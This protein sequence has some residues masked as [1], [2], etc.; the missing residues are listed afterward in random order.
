[1]D[2]GAPIAASEVRFRSLFEN[3]PEL[4][5]YQNPAGIILDANPAF[6]AVVEKSKEQVI[7][8]P[9]SD[10]LPLRAQPIFTQK[11]REA[12]AGK[13]VRFE[14]F[15]SQGQS[16]PRHWDVVK[17]P[18]RQEGEVVGVHMVARDIT[19][20]TQHQEEI[21]VQNQNLQ[22]FAYIVSHNLRAPLANAV[23]LVELLSTEEQG[24]PFFEETR[25]YLQQNLQQLDLVL[26]DMNTI[27]TIRDQQH[28]AVPESVPL[29]EIISQVLQDL[30]DVLDQC[31]GTTQIEIDQHMR[32]QANRAYL[33][34]IF[35]NL[36]TNAIKYR[37]DQ[38]PLHIA[39]AAIRDGGGRQVVTI[40]DNGVGFDQE[41]AGADI[42]KLYKRFHT[43]LSGRG[44]GLYLVKTHV[45]N[46]GGQ[47]EV[48]SQLG[49]GT[50]FTLT[51][52]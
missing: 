7:G 38:R 49:E 5:L 50:R 30:A 20:K 12:I 11:L 25:Q 27:L 46:M 33:Y 14:V 29:Q 36:L 17:I 22:Q 26:R 4:V 35:F 28:L 40:T 10:F 18:L 39:I 3:T 16:A 37:S 41:Q 19:E 21:F 2:A 45:E 23:G 44:V 47:I 34:S 43:K 8:K 31:G 13:T 32:V 51:L 9:Y 24:S 48:H 52:R 6:L 42:F 15:A 1:M